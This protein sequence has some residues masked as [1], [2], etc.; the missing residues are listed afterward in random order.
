MISTEEL[1]ELFKLE[2]TVNYHKLP[3]VDWQTV[4]DVEKKSDSQNDSRIL[5]LI[6]LPHSQGSSN[7]PFVVISE[8]KLHGNKSLSG[9]M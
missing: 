3:Y 5:E 1:Q 8:T 9:R 2:G 4:C 7:F 6:E